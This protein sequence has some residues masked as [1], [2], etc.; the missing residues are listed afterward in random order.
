[1]KYQRCTR[2]VMDNMNDSYITFDKDGVCSYCTEALQR[3]PIVY[4][5]NKIGEMKLNSL[6]AKLKRE[7]QGKEYDCMMGISGGLDSSFLAMLGFK[8]GLRILA[9]HIDDGFDTE[10]AKNNIEKLCKACKINLVTIKPD[11]EQFHGLTKAFILSGS[12]DLDTPQ[13][14]VLFATLHSFAKKYKIKYFL[15]G[16][17]FALESIL[18]PLSASN[19]Y[20][21]KRIRYIHKKYGN[22]PINKLH[23][24]SNYQRVFDKFIYQFI[25]VRPLNYI[26]Y[27][28]VKAIEELED[29]CEFQ[30]YEAKHCENY[31]TK[32]IQLYWLPKK[33]GYDRRKSHLS[34]LII[35]NQLDRDIAIEE[36][37]SPAYNVPNMER[38]LEYVLSKLNMERDDFDKI[39]ADRSKQVDTKKSIGYCIVKKYLGCFLVRFKG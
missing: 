33:F 5:P 3:K 12:P 32:V 31:L 9:V 16:G 6:V 28:K 7:G 36:L 4:F 24:M 34:S 18:Q 25:S 29:F 17:N 35:T 21:T 23:I 1:M 30:Y 11:E 15:S 39:M 10:I 13:D 37:K 19:A 20:D 26:H 27:N 2:C 8:W 38:D 22:V 14:N